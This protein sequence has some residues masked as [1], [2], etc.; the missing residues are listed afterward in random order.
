MEGYIYKKRGERGEVKR[1][2]GTYTRKGEKGGERGS[3][4]SVWKGKKE[5]QRKR[6]E[7][8]DGLSIKYNFRP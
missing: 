2:R 1:G 7:R 3:Q 5:Q 4:Q 8:R 6:K